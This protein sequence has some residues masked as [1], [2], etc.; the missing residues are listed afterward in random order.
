MTE[1]QRVSGTPQSVL[2]TI[3]LNSLQEEESNFEILS[4]IETVHAGQWKTI[5][6]F[7]AYTLQ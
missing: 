6:T 3:S 7:N 2:A 1:P 5:F 4:T